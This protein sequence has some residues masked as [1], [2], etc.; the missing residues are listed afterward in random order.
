M[1]IG[2]YSIFDR[3][4]GAFLAPFPARTDADAVRQV[5]S[6]M[7][8]PHLRDSGLVQSPRDFDLTKLAMMDDETGV[9]EPAGSV[10]VVVMNI[11]VIASQI[12][13]GDHA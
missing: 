10:P 5:K 13:E 12:T 9:L 4:V 7:A 1:R 3:V 11:G 6:S 8:N 2:L